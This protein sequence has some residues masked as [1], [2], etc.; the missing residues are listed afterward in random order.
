MKRWLCEKRVTPVK[1]G[2][3]CDRAGLA[4]AEAARD[5]GFVA[6]ETAAEEEDDGDAVLAK[7]ESIAERLRSA[8]TG[9]AAA[10]WRHGQLG[11]SESA[12]VTLEQ[13]QHAPPMP[14]SRCSGSR[15]LH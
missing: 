13:A 4:R 6:V 15:P 7:C 14:L 2:K 12:F 3:V 1:P 11:G 8:A 9:G 10:A 5:T